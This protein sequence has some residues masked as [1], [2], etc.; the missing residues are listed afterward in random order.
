MTTAK[1]QIRRRL[2]SIGPKPG[3]APPPPADEDAAT[4]DDEDQDGDDDGDASGGPK[5]SQAQRLIND[6]VA[7]V[8]RGDVELLHDSDKQAFATMRIAGHWETHPIKSGQFT[9]HL[10]RRFFEFSG[11]RAP[12]AQALADARATIEALAVF[13]GK[14]IP[15]YVRVAELGN[16]IY[17]DLGT[18]DW[19]VVEI[20]AQGWRIVRG[21]HPVRFIRRP[22]MMPLP[23]PIHGGTLRVL[24]ELLRLGDDEFV[25]V[26]A[27]LLAALRR[28]GP[29]PVL[30]V[31]GEAGSGKSSLSRV[32][33]RLVDPNKAETRAEPRDEE[34]LIISATNGWVIVVDNLS[35]MQGWL[36][37]ALC[38]LATGSG[39]AKRQLY[40]DSD[41]I[42]FEA[43]RPIIL[44][45]IEDVASR[46]DLLSR[47]IVLRMPAIPETERCT[48]VDLWAK[49]EAAAPGILGALLT[50]VSTAIRRLPSVKLAKS[51]RMADFAAWAV[52]AEPA[53]GVPEGTFLAAYD[54]NR[55]SANEIALEASSLVPVLRALVD[56]GAAVEM[57]A[58]DLLAV[59]NRRASDEAR[60][61]PDWPRSARALTGALVRLAP[62][63]RSDGIH[64]RY[65]RTA[66]RRVWIIEMTKTQ[67]SSTT[68]SP[69]TASAPEG[70][71]VEMTI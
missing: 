69:P 4:L 63:L 29:F 50:A 35:R 17:L 15:T 44:N 41:E 7:A 28:R 48:E 9:L 40:T 27:W 34:D 45:G 46:G 36:S 53:L 18:P 52:A 16:K 26:A 56:D 64:C 58:G 25:L 47:A 65:Q 13:G 22:G 67:P 30:A 37:D 66:K 10:R 54:L 23:V 14:Q 21:R 60:R 32:T 51:P 39:F 38:R 31:H 59:L 19:S 49:F 20:D 5:P 24:R 12:N 11:G 57:S 3:D 1:H 70:D 61:S 6:V 8:E 62:N 42:I 33:R 68:E 55:A 71:T 2:A 43:Q